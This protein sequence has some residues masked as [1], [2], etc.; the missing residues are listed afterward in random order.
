MVKAQLFSDLNEFLAQ[1]NKPVDSNSRVAPE[2]ALETAVLL[3][4]LKGI[5]KSAKYKNDYFYRCYLNN[6]TTQSDGIFSIQFSYRAVYDSI[7][8][9]KASFHVLAKKIGDHYYFHSPLLQLTKSWKTNKTG[10]VTFHY[11][12]RLN[13]KRATVYVQ[14]LKSFDAKL[15]LSGHTTEFYSCDDFNEAQAI[16]GLQYKVDYSGIAFNSLSASHGNKSI[17]VAG[18]DNKEGFNDV[19]IHDLWHDRLH[20]K[21][22]AERIN[23]PVDEGCAY[24]YGGSWGIPWPKIM[25]IIKRYAATHP[26]ANWLNMYNES[27]NFSADTQRPLRADFAINALI[28]KMIEAEKGFPKV[29]ELLCCGKLETGNENYFRALVRITGITKENFNASVRT[30]ILNAK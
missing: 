24:L 23:R 27:Y 17:C 15:G 22:S 20:S 10:N 13:E 8:L 6:L 25:D 18:A 7:P 12:D 5:E 1:K 21:V 9:L 29:M 11:K 2:Y 4:E 30:L 16:T 26:D 3:D 14:K 19:D 28:V